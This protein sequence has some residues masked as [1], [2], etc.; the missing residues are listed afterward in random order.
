[1]VP[2]CFAIVDDNGGKLEIALQVSSA[3]R[4]VSFEPEPSAS[5]L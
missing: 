3:L 2:L 5:M 1:M 4:N